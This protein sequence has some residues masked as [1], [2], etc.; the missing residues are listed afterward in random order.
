MTK[1]NSCGAEFRA[2]DAGKRVPCTS[3]GAISRVFEDGIALNVQAG[4]HVTL[5]LRRDEQTI[6]LRES[7]R[8]GRVTFADEENG[9]ITTFLTGASP[10]GE[11]D[12]LAV[13]GLQ[14]PHHGSKHN[15]GPAILN[16][17]IG[18]KK[19]NEQII[20][21]AIVSA[22]RK[23]EPKHP[24]KKVVNAFTRR[25]AKAVATQGKT[26]CFRGT[27]TPARAGWVTADA[28]PFSNQVEE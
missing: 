28:L 11:T 21:T 19:P 26:I 16:L 4:D 27:D 10:Q 14:V 7:E 9:L 17:I 12:T 22:P 23:G 24:S 5:E 20:K 1:C 2:N 6:G 25:G 15:V 13:K 8:D 18:P 3:S